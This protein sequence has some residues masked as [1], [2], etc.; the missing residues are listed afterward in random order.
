MT[1]VF[2]CCM[3]F[4][5]L[6][7]LELRMNILALVV[8]YF[9]VVEAGMTHSGQPKPQTVGNALV[10]DRRFAPFADQ[11]IYSYRPD[12]PG[13]NAWERER[14]NRAMI[15][16]V[17]RFNAAPEDW[18]IVGDADE[19]ANPD[20]VKVLKERRVDRPV[21]FELD[22]YY[23]DF[24]HHV[25]AGWAVGACHWGQEQDANRIRTCQFDAPSG[26][27]TCL[28]GGWHFSYFGDAQAIMR[29][30]QAFMHHDWVDAFHLTPER[31]QAALDAGTDL[32]GRDLTI[33]RVPLSDSLPRYVLGNRAK[34]AALGWLEAEMVAK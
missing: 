30:V 2:D 33:E 18:V 6:D 7:M 4:N 1:K 19:I 22:F 26:I 14:A 16:D 21:K 32:W 20:A 29:K 15:S 27:N 31:V 28:E 9:V 10:S 3:V 11:I 13:A 23:Y 12:L 25:K 17:L 8:D 34:Y 5:E 24:N